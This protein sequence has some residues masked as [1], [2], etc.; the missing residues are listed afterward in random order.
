MP[1]MIRKDL[2]G[3]VHDVDVSPH[4]GMA[5]PMRRSQPLRQF[6]LICVRHDSLRVRGVGQLAFT[7]PLQGRGNPGTLP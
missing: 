2:S 6:G 5:P 4:R 7:R 3:G 1:W